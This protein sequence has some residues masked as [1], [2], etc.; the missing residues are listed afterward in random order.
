MDIVWNIAK[1]VYG[2]IGVPYPMLSQ[3]GVAVLGAILG[4]VI[5]WSSWH[6]LAQ[7]YQKEQAS[8]VSEAKT[9]PNQS[10]QSVTNS[11]NSPPVQVTGNN[12]NVVVNNATTDNVSTTGP[13]AIVA[14]GRSN[15]KLDGSLISGYP[16]AIRTSD[17]ATVSGQGNVIEKGDQPKQ[18]PPPTGEFR[19][20]SN[21]DL[22][23]RVK[24]LADAMRSAESKADEKT[25]T[26]LMRQQVAQSPQESKKN[27]AEMNA[28]LEKMRNEQNGEFQRS[29]RPQATALASEMLARL[30]SIQVPSDFDHS[31]VRSG[32]EV[33]IHGMLVG[34]HPMSAAADFL[35]F[36]ANRLAQ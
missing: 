20:L 24:T 10:T 32:G 26:L 6:G 7:Q 18:F 31:S 30:R 2:V 4:A 19:N 13:A 25:S 27:W 3:I 21:S 16:T 34:P 12:N 11:P 5:A 35:E 29:F 1:S 22:R 14:G 8:V 23:G 15:V 17:E 33:L 36:M 28:Q 9:T